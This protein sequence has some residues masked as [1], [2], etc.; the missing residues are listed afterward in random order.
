MANGEWR[1]VSGRP[2]GHPIRY[3]LFAIRRRAA[4]AHSLFAGAEGALLPILLDSRGAQAGEAVAI[5]GILPGEEFFDRQRVTA[6][7]FLEREESAA[8]GGHHFGLAA[9][10]PPLGAGCRQIGNGERTSVRPNHILSPRTMGLAH[11]QHSHTQR[12]LDRT[13]SRGA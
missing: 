7:G 1:M 8:H 4:G 11:M 10:D 12:L 13:I 2:R 6:A 3:S 5:D 9:D